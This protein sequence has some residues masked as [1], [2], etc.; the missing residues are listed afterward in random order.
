MPE[1]PDVEIFRQYLNAT[2]LHQTIETVDINAGDMLKGISETKL[3]QHLRKNQFISGH[4]HGKYLFAELEKN[5]WLVLHFGMTGFLKYFKN[6]ENKPGHVRLCI[7]F[8]NKYHLVYDCMRKL[9]KI[10]FTDS[11]NAFVEEQGLGPDVLDPDLDQESFKGILSR[12]RGTIKGALMNQRMFAGIGNIYADEILFQAGI[13]PKIK[14]NELKDNALEKLFRVMR[15]NVLTTAIQYRADSFKF[16]DS[17]IIPHRKKGETCP[18]C[19]NGLQQIKVS[20]RTTYLCPNCQQ[21]IG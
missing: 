18:N 21:K 9:G 19:G 6:V 20:G 13:H 5:G 1:L 17:Y 16:P 3:K 14:V 10:G 8:S 2:S 7:G 12:S 4:R 11:L 15:R